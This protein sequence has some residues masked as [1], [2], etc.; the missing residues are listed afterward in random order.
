MLVLGIGLIVCLPLLFGGLPYTG[1]LPHHY[2]TALGF[3]DSMLNG[4]YYPSWHPG[5]NGGYGDPSVRFYPP[6]LYFLLA[7]G[8]LILGDWFFASLA[9]SMLLTIAGSIGMYL[10]ARSFTNRYYALAAGLIFLL[11][12][13][14]TN[15]MYQAGMYPQYAAGSV[16]PFVFASVERIIRRG[17]NRHVAGLAISYALLILF[18]VPLAVIGSI[19]LALYTLIRLS[20]SF[21]V[22]A[23]CR[24]VGGVLLAAAVSCFYWA[25]VAQELKWKYPSGVGQGAWFDYR[26]NFLFVNSPSVMSNFLLPL[27]VAATFAMAIPAVILVLRKDRLALAPAVVGA[28]AFFMSLPASKVIWDQLP[29]LQETQFPWRWMTVSSACLALLVTMSL[30]ELVLRAYSAWRPVVLVL[31]GSLLIAHTFTITQLIRGAPVFHRAAFNERVNS[32]KDAKTNRDFLPIW[33]SD[34]PR[35]MGAAVEALNRTVTIVD[36]SAER[37]VFSISEGAAEEVRLR[38]FYYPYWQGFAS[39]SKLNTR[40]D[41]EGILLVTIPSAKTTVE[42]KFVEPW[43][44]YVSAYISL[45]ALASILLTLIFAYVPGLFPRWSTRRD[46]PQPARSPIGELKAEYEPDV[47]L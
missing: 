41:D 1:D 24:L 46:E 33:A 3:Y 42:V 6:A 47:Q 32:Q 35:K 11:A 38:T 18:H 19:A 20:Q 29:L 40:P 5:T 30:S 43:T 13:F 10:W 44:T 23:A 16:L 25:P 17:L 4:N 12:P 22:K 2:R 9:T 36:W 14:H 28:F 37:K 27:L 34:Q 39:G 45:L 26:N 7:G 31:V 21:S 8:R 15:E